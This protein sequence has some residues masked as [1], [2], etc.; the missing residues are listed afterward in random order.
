MRNLLLVA[1]MIVSGAG[2]SPAQPSRTD[3][4]YGPRPAHSVFDPS[5]VLAPELV[6]KISD[7]LAELYQTQ[8]I[9]I[10]VVILR[11]LKGA[12]PQHVARSFAN[13]WCRSAIQCIVLHV[14]GQ[15]DSPWIVPSGKIT[16]VISPTGIS[17]AVAGIQKR[18]ALEKD[19]AEIVQI[20]ANETTHMLRDWVNNVI[21]VSEASR[22][23]RVKAEAAQKAH[24]QLLKFGL[25]LGVCLSILLG[26]IIFSILK[27]IQKRRPC[28]FPTR[29]YPRRLGAP[30][31]GGNHAVVKL[32]PVRR[33]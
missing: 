18:A 19:Q 2:F 16:R 20:A 23:Q 26:G 27:K 17:L 8:G 13:A 32:G 12:P 6:K 33:E 31:A 4:E 3:F 7:P 5:G 22:S 25:F 10:F 14:P 28:F 15:P 29:D 1:T 11:D 21:N 9:D 24:S 30:H